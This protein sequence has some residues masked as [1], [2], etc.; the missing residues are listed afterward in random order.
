[1]NNNYNYN[2]YN[3]YFKIEA[4]RRPISLPW[5]K[6]DKMDGESLVSIKKEGDWILLKT[7]DGH[8]VH[9]NEKY[10]VWEIGLSGRMH[11]K[12]G[13]LLG[14]NDNEPVNDLD[15]TDGRSNN[16]VIPIFI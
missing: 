16:L 5:Q 8:H 3:Y 6:V 12:I 9:Y 10:K 13:G 2:N 7:Y 15:F 11:A 4:D 14:L 1:M